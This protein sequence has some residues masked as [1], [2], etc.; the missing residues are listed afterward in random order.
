MEP[1]IHL[2]LL[3]AVLLLPAFR[4]PRRRRRIPM[5]LTIGL[6]ALSAF[7]LLLRLTLTEHGLYHEDTHG[8]GYLQFILGGIPFYDGTPVSSFVVLSHLSPLLGP[9]HE[10]VFRANALLSALAV[11]FVGRVAVQ[12]SER[13]LAGWAAGAMWAITPVSIVM[14]PTEIMFN[15]QVLL[16][17]MATSALLEGVE[18]RS[19]PLLALG[20][21][22]LALEAQSRAMSLVHPVTVL[23]LCLVATKVRWKEAIRRLALPS[24]FAA[25]LVAPWFAHR[26]TAGS[27]MRSPLRLDYLKSNLE[28]FSSSADLGSVVSPFL[29]AFAALGAWLFLRRRTASHTLRNALLLLVGFVAVAGPPAAASGATVAMTRFFLPTLALSTTLAGCG[30]AFL[31]AHV[32]ATRGRTWTAVAGLAL[33]ATPALSFSYITAPRV[34]GIEY[35]LLTREL[36]LRLH[37]LAPANLAVLLH[38]DGPFWDPGNNA[39]RLLPNLPG[40]TATLPRLAPTA[41]AQHVFVGHACN[42]SEAKAPGVH[43]ADGLPP[44]RE[45]CARALGGGRWQISALWLLPSDVLAHSISERPGPKALALLYRPPLHAEPAATGGA[46]LP[47]LRRAPCPTSFRHSSQENPLTPHPKPGS[48]PSLRA[49][50]AHLT[51]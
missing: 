14:G 13:E 3:A 40:W 29:W 21:L 32:R 34:D 39:E 4:M 24:V 41:Q 38:P 18:S 49:P 51:R 46:H 15:V 23:S 42:E 43:V 27:Y 33:A 1:L 22:L 48:I 37:G 12:W 19:R 5:R 36:P 45:A 28:S 8:W 35:R 6:F 9:G 47:K 44:L 7:G 10:G 16:L 20:A 50:G 25:L 26:L 31:L 2:E 11:V 30:L 17:L